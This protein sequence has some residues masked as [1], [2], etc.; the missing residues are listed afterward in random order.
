MP[1][2]VARLINRIEMAQDKLRAKND[3]VL[4]SVLKSG[5]ATTQEIPDLRFP[6]ITSKQRALPPVRERPRL[7]A[8][9]APT[10]MKPIKSTLKTMRTA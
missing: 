3:V 1:P 4:N 7:G 6:T 10:E 9:S 2:Q 8:T 5:G